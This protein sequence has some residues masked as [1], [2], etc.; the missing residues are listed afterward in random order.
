MIKLETTKEEQ[1]LNRAPGVDCI[2]GSIPVAN[3]NG[4]K[5]QF[6]EE[7]Q[8]NWSAVAKRP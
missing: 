1:E 5:Q 8:K 6:S 3:F 4:V 7:V 2:A